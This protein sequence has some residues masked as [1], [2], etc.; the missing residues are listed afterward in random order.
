ME[1]FLMQINRLVTLSNEETIGLNSIVKA[2]SYK[3]GD[4]VLKINR[5][6]K[7]LYFINDGLVKVSFFNESKEFVMK[8]FYKHEFCAVLDSLTTNQP[9]NY[10]IIALTDVSLLEIDFEELNKLATQYHSFEKII[11]TIS[12]IAI[13][14]MMSRVRE[15]LETDARERYLN[16]L[17]NNS[18]LMY[19]V[20]LKDLSAY[21]G[22]SQ[23]SLSRI[24]AKV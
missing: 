22:I 20:S 18:H 6:N 21:L 17:E 24:R 5:V 23:V 1:D 2:K 10:T 7:K 16:F 9:S 12:S 13:N 15:L 3:K 11:S 4:T 19:L 14:K 8:F